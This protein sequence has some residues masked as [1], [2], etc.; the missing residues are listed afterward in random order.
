M[1]SIL[2]RIFW[3]KAYLHLQPFSWTKKA[4]TLFW[5]LIC[6]SMDPAIF[7]E[8]WCTTISI[9]ADKNF[10]LSSPKTTICHHSQFILPLICPDHH[11]IVPLPLWKSQPLG[12][13]HSFVE[14]H[15]GPGLRAHQNQII[16]QAPQKPRYL[17]K[18]I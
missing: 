18:I 9:Q 3:Y 11:L 4:S 7:G 14:C 17:G 5:I 10:P 6:I 2:P 12:P 13:L 1:N 8:I 15:H 16:H